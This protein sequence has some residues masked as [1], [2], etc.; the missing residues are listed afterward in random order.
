MAIFYL[1]RHGEA[2]YS[3]LQKYNFYGFGRDFAP[4]TPNGIIQAEH[5]SR[6]SRLKSADIIISSPY[7]RAL[8]T[9]QIISKNT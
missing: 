9:A 6:D 8:Q 3:N 4:L 5:A 7:T 1:I 2:D